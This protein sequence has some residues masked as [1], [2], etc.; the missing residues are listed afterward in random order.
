MVQIVRQK[1]ARR[2]NACSL[3]RAVY[4]TL[5]DIVPDP[6]TKTLTIRL[7]SLASESPD[8]AV[9]PSCARRH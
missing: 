6:L 3:L 7:H 2:D 5:V 4:A 1:M 8:Q 9:P